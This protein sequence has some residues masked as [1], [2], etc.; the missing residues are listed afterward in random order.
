[1]SSYNINYGPEGTTLI[2]AGG[3]YFLA[4]EDPTTGMILYWKLTMDALEN[5]TD[6]PEGLTFDNEGNLS[7]EV[8]G[9][10]VY[11]ADQWKSL[12]DNGQVWF[13][14]QLA[15]IKDEDFAKW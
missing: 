9:F 14:G 2:Q 1:M 11:T 7:T 6:A 12:E 15:E 5:I 10:Q 13:A 3:E 4:Y 8:E